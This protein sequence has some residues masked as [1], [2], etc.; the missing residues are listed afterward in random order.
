MS[1]FLSLEMLSVRANE[2]NVACFDGGGWW[3]KKEDLR[4]LKEVFTVTVEKSFLD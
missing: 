3:V 4:V 2:F 1:V